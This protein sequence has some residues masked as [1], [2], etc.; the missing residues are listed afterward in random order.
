MKIV[1]LNRWGFATGMIVIVCSMLAAIGAEVPVRGQYRVID[2]GRISGFRSEARGINARGDIAGLTTTDI[3]YQA[4]RWRWDTTNYVIQALGKGEAYGIADDG[5]VAGL[6]DSTGA[7]LWAPGGAPTSLGLDKGVNAISASGIPV[8]YIYITLMNPNPPFNVK[9]PKHAAAF[10][11]G[12]GSDLA[13]RPEWDCEVAGVDRIGIQWVGSVFM[14]VFAGGPKYAW[15][16]PGQINHPILSPHRHLRTNGGK[17][18]ANDHP[19]RE[20]PAIQ[21]N[22]FHRE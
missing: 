14:N 15:L 18:R 20:T 16:F 19:S 17:H 9:F 7:T 2:L 3:G 1:C 22:D 12:A 10:A 21:A 4:A 11:G 5:T 13:L 8:G 6:G